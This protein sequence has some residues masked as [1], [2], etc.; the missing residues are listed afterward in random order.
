MLE[1]DYTST[2][3]AKLCALELR[4]KK[5]ER[6]YWRLKNEYIATTQAIA[7]AKNEE[8]LKQ[9]S[10]KLDTL[11]QALE[12]SLEQI[13]IARSAQICQRK[14]AKELAQAYQTGNEETPVDAWE[15]KKYN[16][17]IKKLDADIDG[18][19]INEDKISIWT[20][21]NRF[22]KNKIRTDTIYQEAGWYTS[23]R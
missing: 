17:A 19:E 21:I 6:E 7:K 11:H 18:D 13:K 10:E 1:H 9:L 4:N 8:A 22:F 23:A 3:K 2:E 5:V 20:R 14:M 15:V 16:T 12:E